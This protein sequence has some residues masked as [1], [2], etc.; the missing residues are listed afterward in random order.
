MKKSRECFVDCPVDITHCPLKKAESTLT[1]KEPTSDMQIVLV[2]NYPKTSKI[3]V[4]CR[5]CA[6]QVNLNDYPLLNSKLVLK[7]SH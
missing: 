4:S 7:V 6:K 5:D 3:F 2:T 1:P